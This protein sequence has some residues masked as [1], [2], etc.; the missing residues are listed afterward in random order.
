MYYLSVLSVF[1]KKK[2]VVHVDCS[3]ARV[4][5]FV[6]VCTTLMVTLLSLQDLHEDLEKNKP[7]LLSAEDSGQRL[8]EVYTEEL[9]L[10]SVVAT[11]LN[12]LQQAF[13]I[14]Y[15]AVV[16][17]E[18][19]LQMRL[20]QTQELDTSFADVIRWLVEMERTLSRQEPIALQPV[21]VNRQKNDQEVSL[22]SVACGVVINVLLLWLFLLKVMLFVG[23]KRMHGSVIFYHRHSP[24]VVGCLKVI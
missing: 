11:K 12:P 18:G 24:W 4:G 17:R 20:V 19:Q 8:M 2:N 22:G 23:S 16:D 14:L 9:T 13:E 21:K 7:L 6:I 15:E 10:D 5:C 3:K 1:A